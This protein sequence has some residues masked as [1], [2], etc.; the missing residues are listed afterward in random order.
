[1]CLID[2]GSPETRIEHTDVGFISVDGFQNPGSY[3]RMLNY[4]RASRAVL[5]E[6]TRRAVYCEQS[7]AYRCWNAKLLA[8]PQGK[9]SLFNLCFA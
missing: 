9:T 2:R 7:V 1:M 5:S 4:G 3:S 6:L 8:K